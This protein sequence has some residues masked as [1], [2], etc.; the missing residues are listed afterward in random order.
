[1]VPSTLRLETIFQK[2]C[3]VNNGEC[4]KQHKGTTEDEMV[5]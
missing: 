3:L 5:G 4:Y 1:M 2:L